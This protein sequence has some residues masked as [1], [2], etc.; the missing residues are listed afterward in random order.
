M[1]YTDLTG[2]NEATFKRIV[3][4]PRVLF[5]S[6]VAVLEAAE[7]RKLKSGCPTKLSIADQL[8]LTLNYWREYRTYAHLGM[9]YGI[10]EST[11]QRTVKRI[12]D[13]LVASEY[14]ALTQAALQEPPLAVIVD[15]SET[16]IERPKKN[17]MSSTVAR[18]ILTP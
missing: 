15:A 8:L 16:P 9:D 18:S 2:L 13:R 5:Q 4:I 3:G 10:H 7:R 1:R 6:L 17:R 12:E 11:A 14:L